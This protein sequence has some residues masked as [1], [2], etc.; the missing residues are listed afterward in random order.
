MT[1][2]AETPVIYAVEPLAECLK[3]IAAIMQDHGTAF[4]YYKHLKGPVDPDFGFYE[5]FEEQGR[6]R[7]CTAR[8]DSELVGYFIIVTGPSAHYKNL[9]LCIDD[10]FYLKPEYRRGFGLYF[11]VKYCADQMQDFGGA[12]SCLVISDKENQDMK[13]ILKR[14]GFAPEEIRWTKMVEI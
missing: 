6:L 8:H 10:T 5:T 4:T 3:G 14:L 1:A 2:A 9:K 11:F 7:I 13:P 12:G